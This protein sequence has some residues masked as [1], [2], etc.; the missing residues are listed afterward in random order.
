MQPTSLRRQKI[1]SL[2]SEG[3]Y[4]LS[5]SPHPARARQDAETLLLHVL[6]K[7]KAWLI[8][9]GEEQ[10][11]GDQAARYARLLER[12][13][14]GE[15][16]QYITG[17]AEFYGLPFRVMRD[18]LIPRPETEHSVEKALE[19]ASSFTTPRIVDVGTGSGVIAVALAHELSQRAEHGRKALKGTGFSPYV[20]AINASGALAPEGNPSENLSV[21]PAI[22]TAIDLS[23]P[24]LAIARENAKR[25]GVSIRFLLG[26]LLAPVAGEQFEMVVSNPPYVPGADR[27]TLS[28][29]VRDYEPEMALFAGNDGLEIYRRLI[30]AAF[31]ALIPGGFVV[32]EIGYG[33]SPAIAELLAGSG[34]EQIEFVPDLQGIPR[35]ACARRPDKLS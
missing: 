4:A 10:L 12:R 17:E 28:V 25:N 8:A 11:P 19:L 15:P 22:V 24:A 2:V 27:A 35:V 21:T 23:A 7:D 31:D 33:Q 9:H 3:E 29:E 34:F 30:P 16:I 13:F 26:D 20:P 14:R 32:L 1:H 5:E 18:V 6:G